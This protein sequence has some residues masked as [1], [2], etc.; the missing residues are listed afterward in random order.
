MKAKSWKNLV[1]KKRQEEGIA[2]QE[3]QENPAAPQAGWDLEA[4]AAGQEEQNQQEEQEDAEGIPSLESIAE[5]NDDLR[6]LLDERQALEHRMS[7]LLGG[8]DPLQEPASDPRFA[9]GEIHSIRQKQR[10]DQ[11]W[12]EAR[13][14]AAERLK[15]QEEH[16]ANWTRKRDKQYGSDA[17]TED[18]DK[19]GQGTQPPVS[20]SR[21]LQ[22][23]QQEQKRF[24]ELEDKASEKVEDLLSPS[25]LLSG[26]KKKGKKASEQHKEEVRSLTQGD[27]LHQRDKQRDKERLSKAGIAS[28]KQNQ[29][30]DWEAQRDRKREKGQKLRKTLGDIGRGLKTAGEQI[31]KMADSMA[32]LDRKLDEARAKAA[33]ARKAQG[34]DDGM[35]SGFDDS[36]SLFAKKDAL[37]DKLRSNPVVQGYEKF[38]E[39]QKEV[40]EAKKQYEGIIKKALSTDLGSMDD[41]AAKADAL[42]QKALEKKRQQKAEE[43]KEEERREK[44]RQKKKERF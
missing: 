21:F 32:D 2:W 3:Q 22:K 7:H 24:S 25:R 36:N 34:M 5:D 8:G 15:K 14:R 20:D 9:T 43:K 12:E 26:G 6:D 18:Y 35:D 44:Q 38:R 11:R 41:L 39:K 1:K 40:L 33:E 10:I 37:K 31:G 16:I 30:K 4:L 28:D 42:R 29:E 13:K 19:P 17:S 27:D 23:L